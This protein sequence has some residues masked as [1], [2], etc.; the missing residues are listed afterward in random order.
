MVPQ[1]PQHPQQQQHP[2]HPNRGPHPQPGQGH[3]QPGHKKKKKHRRHNFYNPQHQQNPEFQGLPQ[4]DGLDVLEAP[5]PGAAPAGPGQPQAPAQPRPTVT[6][7]LEITEKGNGYIRAEVRKFKPVPADP[8]VPA[9]LIVREA[10]RMGLIVTAELGPRKQGPAPVAVRIT[11]VN[12]K[13]LE[14][15]HQMMA[16]ADL[17]VIDPREKVRLET[18]GGPA[19]M[20]IMDLLCPIGRGQRGLIVAP[21]KTGKTTLLKEIAHA[22]LTNHPDMKVFILLIDE[23]PEEVTDFRRSLPAEVWA[24]NADE[25]VPS[26]VRTARMVIERA[27]RMVEFGAH[28]LVMLD[29]ITRLGRA[30]NHHVGSTGRTMSG[31][32]DASAM[33]EPRAMFGAARNIEHGGSLTIIASAL[34]DTGSRMDE[35][36]FQEFKGTGNMELV[37]SKKLAERRVW[38]AIDLPASGT[39][40]EE[41][42]LS[43]EAI[44]K[45]ALLRRE[46][47]SRDPVQAMEAL[48]FAMRRF[49]TNDAFLAGFTLPGN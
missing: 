6:G 37:L 30:F 33:Q 8:F 13:P 28:V 4:D 16:F 25:D 44:R 23:R 7:L 42:L 22:A 14:A 46:M 5:A 40:K 35:L 45:V 43:P 17:T 10:L 27:K 3:G 24:S 26:H 41:L 31:G 48:L 18:A 11:E 2:Q 21:P 39:R 15:Y 12:G 9:E 32:I 49:P 1:H 19:S 47:L 29:S 20:R 34:I 38:P 36:I